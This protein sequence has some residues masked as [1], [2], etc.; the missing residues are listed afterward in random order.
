MT[1][2][3]ITFN[4]RR[5]VKNERGRVGRRWRWK[6]VGGGGGGVRLVLPPQLC[7]GVVELLRGGWRSAA[8]VFLGGEGGWAARV[9]VS[10][11]RRRRM[12]GMRGGENPCFVTLSCD[13]SAPTLPPPINAGSCRTRS[14]GPRLSVPCFPSLTPWPPTQTPN[15]FFFM[16]PPTTHVFACCHCCCSPTPLIA[17]TII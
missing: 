7:R 4:P 14:S 8:L 6:E 1:A 17:V 9:Q 5:G 13:R 2:S 3:M 10:R 12:R 16:F 11:R 15:A